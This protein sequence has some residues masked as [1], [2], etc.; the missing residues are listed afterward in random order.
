MNTSTI[1]SNGNHKV[2]AATRDAISALP[3][4][5]W[6]LVV[7]LALAGCSQAKF[8]PLPPLRHTFLRFDAPTWTIEFQGPGPGDSL[9][10][11]IRDANRRVG[12]GMTE[13]E[14]YNPA[15]MERVLMS[16]LEDGMRAHYGSL[17]IAPKGR[18]VD[19]LVAPAGWLCRQ[20]LI[21]A[22]TVADA[23]AIFQCVHS[24]AGAWRSLVIVTSAQTGAKDIAAVNAVLATVR[25]D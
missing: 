7:A 8:E 20:Y 13:F 17:T 11:G 22:A 10:V 2:E 24:D 23:N 3:S 6:I 14:D 18:P 4:A 19:A 1:E 16:Q 12:I 5:R 25:T 15:R 21:P 9:R